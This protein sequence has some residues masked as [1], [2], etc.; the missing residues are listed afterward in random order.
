MWEHTEGEWN[1]FIDWFVK[2]YDHEKHHESLN[3][4]I[5]DK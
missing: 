4:V 3:S 5:G 1:K 2:T